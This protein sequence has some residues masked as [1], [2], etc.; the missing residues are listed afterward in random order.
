MTRNFET[1]SDLPKRLIEEPNS[2]G[3]A[4][5]AID[6]VLEPLICRRFTGQVTLTF[7]MNEGGLRAVKVGTEEILKSKT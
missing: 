3:K 5:A 7:T 4:H 6:S 1:P 2:R